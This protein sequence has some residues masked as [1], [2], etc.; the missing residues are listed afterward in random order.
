MSSRARAL[1][2][3]ATFPQRLTGSESSAPEELN[4]QK[5]GMDA[6]ADLSD[7][8]EVSRKR[9]TGASRDRRRRRASRRPPRRRAS[10]RAPTPERVLTPRNSSESPASAARHQPPRATPV[11]SPP[12]APHAQRRRARSSPSPPLP[13]EVRAHI[14]HSR[15]ARPSSPLRSTRSDT[16]PRVVGPLASSRRAREP[17]RVGDQ[18]RAPRSLHQTRPRVG[19]RPDRTPHSPNS[20]VRCALAPG[21]VSTSRPRSSDSLAMRRARAPRST[22]TGSSAPQFI[23]ARSA[24][25]AQLRWPCLSSCPARTHPVPRRRVATHQDGG[26]EAVGQAERA[27]RGADLRGST[28]RPDHVPGQR[29]PVPSSLS[30]PPQLVATH[31]AE[32]AIASSVQIASVASLRL[33]LHP[34]GQRE[35]VEVRFA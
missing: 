21:N 3:A 12:N 9:R 14:P 16:V 6:V 25:S 32:L 33:A 23:G 31:P 15:A 19:S 2:T 24:S 28:G 4:P 26:A 35:T 30:T 18:A 10:P 11:L 22:A 13:R 20:L 8:G 1:L 17:V 7:G 27:T 29:A 34:A 5:Y